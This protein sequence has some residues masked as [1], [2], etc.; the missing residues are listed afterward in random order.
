MDPIMGLIVGCRC[1]II[2]LGSLLRYVVIYDVT[3]ARYLSIE[4]HGKVRV[5]NQHFIVG[6]EFDAHARS[7]AEILQVHDYPYC[8]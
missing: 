6:T 2:Y 4:Q 1:G 8:F 5:R 7:G 3:R